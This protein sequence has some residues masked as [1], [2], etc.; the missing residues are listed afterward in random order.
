MS[1]WDKLEQKISISIGQPFLIQKTAEVVG[2][3]I[4]Q[5]RRIEGVIK[6]ENKARHYFIK[7]NQ[8]NRL[9]MFE[10]EAAGLEEIKKVQAIRVPAVICSGVEENQSYLILENLTFAGAQP[11]S[12]NQLGQ[13]LALMHKTIANT[14]GWSCNNTIGSTQQRNTQT[15]SWINFW[16]E[17][18]LGFQ[19]ELAKQ[20]GAEPSLY[21]KG[22]KL[23]DELER[24]FINYQPVPS[25]L[26]GDLWSGNFSY[27]QNGEPVIFD[28]A[29]YYG[30]RETDIA[31]TE[32]FGG[33][34]AEFYSAYNEVW[35][36][37]KGYKQRKALYNLYHTL[38][39]YNLFGGGYATQA[40]NMI[41][42]LLA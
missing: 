8:K 3:D 30:D 28:P 38:N 15:D 18:R 11:Q 27:L 12:A 19:L 39:H 29:V 25:L 20:N 34:P 13:Q 16:Q 32:L 33:F 36:L 23:M 9:D 5:A 41:D 37:D 35:P 4:N 42:K 22:N 6:A 14:F 17:Q 7:F 24:F 31:M 40:E 21:I 26:H 10:A 2:G 1:I